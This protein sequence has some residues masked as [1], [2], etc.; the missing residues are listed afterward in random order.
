MPSKLA[1]VNYKPVLGVKKPRDE[2]Q[3][4][5]VV[6]T[7]YIAASFVLMT[8]AGTYFIAL[9]YLFW[10]PRAFYKGRVTL[11]PS[12]ALVFPAIV[13]AYAL[14]STVWSVHP[15]MTARAALEF[16]S[17]I[18]CVAI[19]SQIVS[20]R[21]FIKGVAVGAAA[22]LI[23][24]LVIAGGV[25][26]DTALVGS[27][28]SKNQVGA[29][30]EVGFY[31]ALM[32]WFIVRR[33]DTKV[34]FSLVPLVISAVCLL[35]SR[36]ATSY[37]SLAAM[38]GVSSGA[39]IIGKLPP[40]SRMPSFIG[41]VFCVLV[42]T[43]ASVAFDWKDIGLMAVGKDPTLTGR[44][45]LWSEGIQ[46]GMLNP[47]LGVG[48]GAFWVPGTLEA[49]KLWYQFEMFTRSGFHFHNLFINLFVDLGIL[50]CIAWALM[51]ISTC[52]KSITFVVKAASVESIFY[53]GMS[54]MYLVRSITEVDTP[55]PYGFAPLLFF[56]V[57]IRVAARNNLRSRHPAALLSAKN[58]AR[59]TR[60]DTPRP[61]IW[62]WT[63]KR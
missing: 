3:M 36:S 11:P 15:D 31:C 24:T 33:L 38:L 1:A 22:A 55:G 47:I 25:R 48:F 45:Y 61:L 53:V 12:K 34:L 51:Y 39:Y 7:G 21:A 13:A 20:I 52:V 17:F 56:F 23:V 8:F 37:V 41:V 43:A 27:L 62:D 19:I 4:P 14:A 60:D 49:E 10:L 50:G 44:T 9:F 5:E 6:A 54:F 32:S 2:R 30:G 40:K 58:G 26:G 59:P 46:T 35:Y 57:V 18:V 42:V 29:I 28:G 16:A 63:Q